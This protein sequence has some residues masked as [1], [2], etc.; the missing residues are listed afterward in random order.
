MAVYAKIKKRL[1]NFK[2]DVEFESDNGTLGLLG[3]SGCGKSMTLKC[4]AGIIRPDEGLIEVNGQVLFDS[5]RRIDL[6]PQDRH[7]GLMFQN[8]ALFPN[9]TLRENICSVL[10]HSSR[11]SGIGSKFEELTESL[12][13]KGLEEHYPCQLSGGQQQRAALARIL[14]S[15]PRLIMLDEPLSA[16]DSYLRWQV[17][18]ELYGALASFSG[19]TLYVSHNRD[20]VFRMCRKICVINEG[21]SERICTAE[22]LFSAP[23][24]FSAAMLS[25]CRN[26]SRII[27]IDEKRVHALDWKTELTC[28]DV[29]ED[30][31]YV[32]VRSHH[33]APHRENG[34]NTLQCRITKISRDVFFTSV[35]LLPVD[36]DKKEDL[37]YI[38]M[39]LPNS[40][41]RPISEGQVIN[42]SIGEEDIIPLTA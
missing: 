4:I 15:E 31:R 16:L 28:K 17:E 21:R 11:S 13:L 27:R 37:S 2:L 5:N 22:E 30:I 41:T 25:G 33:V 29:S 39:D 7:V 32:G 10:R 42:V 24:S 38:R 14:A 35:I 6:K 26:Y 8:Y 18:Q 19:T 20:E 12:Y 1:G 36:C 9:M 40:D 3:A 23:S 34:N